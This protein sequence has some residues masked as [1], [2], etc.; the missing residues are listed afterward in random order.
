MYGNLFP[1][2]L[3]P[4][5]FDIG[6]GLV[7]LDDLCMTDIWDPEMAGELPE[8]AC[9]F[10]LPPD[11]LGGG[12]LDDFDLRLPAES[13]VE[14]DQKYDDNCYVKMLSKILSK[15]M[16]LLLVVIAYRNLVEK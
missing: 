8:P 12:R 9:T 6:I 3:F 15:I 16:G 13:A 2:H 7:V 1:A 10:P 11:L 4:D 14:H 5:A